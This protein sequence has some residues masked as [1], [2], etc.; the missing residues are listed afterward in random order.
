MKLIARALLFVAP[1]I[2]VLVG[3]SAAAQDQA[4]KFVS[5]TLVVQAEGTYEADPD[6]ASLTFDISAQEKEMKPAFD[7]AN[8]S[9]R[10]IAELAERNGL[11][12]E[13]VSIGSLTVMPTYEGDRKRRVKSYLVRGQIV[14][15]VRDFSKIGPILDDAVQDEIVDFRSLTYSLADME[16]AKQKAVAEAMKHAIGR[17]SVA[18]EQKG[19]KLGALRFATLDVQQLDEVSELA[20]NGRS[21]LQLT[22][23]TPGAAT[24]MPL[25][26]PVPLPPPP[27]PQ[28]E[29]ITVSATVQCGFQIQ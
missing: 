25:R 29:K 18:L 26:A 24:A 5:D 22:T 1:A 7:K 11:K 20:I 13:D 21:V 2:F 27:L 17:A 15:K 10:K 6:L 23:I 9:V 19:Q 16:A 8:Q 14:L 4:V 28:P 12:K 3:R